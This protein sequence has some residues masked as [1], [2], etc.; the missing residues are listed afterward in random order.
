MFS[1]FEGN[2]TVLSWEKVKSKLGI[3]GF[4]ITLK[5]HKI[6]DEKTYLTTD[7]SGRSVWISYS[8]I[9]WSR[10]V[11]HKSWYLENSAMRLLV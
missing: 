5:K 7:K 4:L 9:S 1:H 2:Q 6:I 8:V 3:E 11:I 10:G